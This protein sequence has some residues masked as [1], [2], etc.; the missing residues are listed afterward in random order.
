MTGVAYGA[1]R[2]VA[3]AVVL[4]T[5]VAGLVLPAPAQAPVDPQSLV[6]EWSGEWQWRSNRQNK[7]PYLL[8]IERVDGATVFGQGQFR[9]R[10]NSE[11]KFRGTL[12]G[13]HL[14]FGRDV[15][16]DLVIDGKSMSG[17]RSGGEA[18]LDL[19][20]TKTR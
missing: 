8:T 2:A 13:N 11:F 20:L 12:E 7:G 1:V 16:T 14:T 10:N 9:G 19:K 4:L 15:H 6:G 18:P 3:M 5:A 17:S